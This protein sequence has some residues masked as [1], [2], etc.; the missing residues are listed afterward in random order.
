MVRTLKDIIKNSNDIY[1]I[2]VNKPSRRD[3]S[4]WEFKMIDPRWTD[5]SFKDYTFKTVHLRRDNGFF[6]AFK[7]DESNAYFVD[8][9]R[10]MYLSC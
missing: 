7:S 6:L 10:A 2:R 9:K 1:E 8:P 3:H 4:T 5:E